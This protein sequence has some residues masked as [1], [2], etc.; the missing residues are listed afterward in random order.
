V[1][2]DFAKI[3][4]EGMSSINPNVGLLELANADDPCITGQSCILKCTALTDFFYL[5]PLRTNVKKII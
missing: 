5:T 3:Q 2:I 1:H 4:A